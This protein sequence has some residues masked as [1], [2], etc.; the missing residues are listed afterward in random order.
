MAI[1]APLHLD[2][3]LLNANYYQSKITKSRVRL[4]H[5]HLAMDNAAPGP[6][7]DASRSCSAMGLTAA[8]KTSRPAGEVRSGT[9]GSRPRI[10]TPVSASITPGLV[11]AASPGLSG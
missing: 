9:S 8:R 11:A 1:G 6:H 5:R 4:M 10:G 7:Q 3:S 2:S